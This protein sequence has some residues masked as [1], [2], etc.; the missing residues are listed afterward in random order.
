MKLNMKH[1]VARLHCA[2]LLRANLPLPSNL[3]PQGPAR[4]Y[5]GNRSNFNQIG[6][7]CLTYTSRAQ[8]PESRHWRKGYSLFRVR[9]PALA[10][11]GSGNQRACWL[12]K[13]ARVLGMDRWV[14]LAGEHGSEEVSPHD[15]L[16]AHRRRDEREPVLPG[17]AGTLR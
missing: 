13:L 6:K 7:K 16:C 10:I 4:T 1:H 11:E 3:R 12:G 17:E 15:Q 14:S 9:R 8:S 5:Q 2:A